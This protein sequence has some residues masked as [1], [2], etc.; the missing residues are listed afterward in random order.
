MDVDQFDAN[1]S[2]MDIPTVEFQHNADDN[3]SVQ[4]KYVA[5]WK[6]LEIFCNF[7][8]FDGKLHISVV[9]IICKFH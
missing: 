5:K 3:T 4:K 6:I 8:S 1:T 7:T 9:K 2:S